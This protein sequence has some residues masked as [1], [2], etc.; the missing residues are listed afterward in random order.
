MCVLPLVEAPATTLTHPEVEVTTTYGKLRERK[1]YRF[2]GDAPTVDYRI[3][4]TSTSNSVKAVMERVFYV[5][6]DEQFVAP[7]EPIGDFRRRLRKVRTMLVKRIGVVPV[8]SFESFI[9]TY[10]GAKK[11]LYTRASAEAQIR[12][13][14]KREA[15]LAS[16]VKMER[17][18]YGAKPGA[19]PRLIQPRKPIF[20][21]RIGRFMKPFEHQLY[22]ALNDIF[23]PGK[24]T[25]MK[26]LNGQQVAAAIVDAWVGF[27]DP[28]AIMFDVSRFD[29]H[30]STPALEYEQSIY[31]N[32]CPKYF[33]GELRELLKAQ[34]VNRGRVLCDDGRVTYTRQGMRAS[35][36]MN[37]AC[38]N[39][40]LMCSLM[41]AFM[42]G[43]C[44]YRFIDNGDDCILIGERSEIKEAVIGIEHWFREMG[45]TL[46]VEGETDQLERIKFCQASPVKTSKGWV[47]AR[48]PRTL[49]KDMT[50]AKNMSNETLRLTW[51]AAVGASGRALN[52]GVPIN[53]AFFQKF[54]RERGKRGV[55]EQLGLDT[56]LFRAAEG[57]IDASTEITIEARLSYERAF[58]IPPYVQVLLENS[59]VGPG[60]DFSPQPSVNYD[61]QG[62]LHLVP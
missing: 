59:F 41:H 21:A 45:F 42:D 15:M 38:G 61:W 55:E 26:G 52:D 30:V 39:V 9:N 14:E 51:L 33:R 49:A 60:H 40:L 10:T 11:V 47:M 23:C 24:D 46:R 4:S 54:P 16:F 37:T 50:T 29:Q 1:A 34:L 22:R 3:H 32:A 18:D 31:L 57:L 20:N 43:K 36:D 56:G 6:E 17:F 8:L 44:K 27:T 7:P 48:N 5:K 2:E 13:F 25:I 12:P 58:G 19:V 35:G 28:Y 53:Y 62:F